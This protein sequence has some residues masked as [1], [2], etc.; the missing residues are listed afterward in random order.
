V[1]LSLPG[2][3]LDVDNPA[4]LQQLAAAPGETR[5]QR[6]ARKWG[7]AALPQAANE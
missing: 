2:I 4:E 5:T 1:V 6:L 7:F 3:A